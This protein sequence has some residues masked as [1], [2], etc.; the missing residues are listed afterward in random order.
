MIVDL[1]RND[2]GR[3][4]EIGSI[5]VT[6]PRVI[7]AHPTVYHGVATIEG[8]LRPEVAFVDILRA[9]FPCGSVTGCPKIRAMEIIDELEPTQRGPYCGAIGYLDADGSMEFSVAIRTMIV[10][11]GEVHVPVGGGVVADSV[12]AEEYAETLVKAK[13]ML[14]ALGASSEVDAGFE[15][16]CRRI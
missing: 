5:K 12:P 8:I 1:Q 6:Q 16:F 10:K 14:A 3:I 4:C 15:G 13:A 11:A 7:E 9:L 2:L